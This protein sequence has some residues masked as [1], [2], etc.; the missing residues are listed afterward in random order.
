MGLKNEWKETG[1]ELLGA[2][3]SLGKTLVRTVKTGANKLDEWAN[4][5]ESQ[6]TDGEEKTAEKKS[7][8]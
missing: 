6:E 1:G 3:T 2:V 8:E 7:D 4:R 5:E